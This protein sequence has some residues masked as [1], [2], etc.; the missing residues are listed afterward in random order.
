MAFPREVLVAGIAVAN[1]LTQGVQCDCTLE[2]WISEDGEGVVTYASPV[3]LR[4]VVDLTRKSRV[5]DGQLVTV[6]AT[7]TVVGDVAPNGA[8]GRY[9]P[10]DPRDRITLP[11]GRTGPILNASD[12]V[13]DPVLGRPFI[14][15]IYLGEFTGQR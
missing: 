15:G 10:I 12:A 5:V 6:V 9:E 13:L 14:N 2:A 4:A 11:D 8:S 7:L 1:A 3:T